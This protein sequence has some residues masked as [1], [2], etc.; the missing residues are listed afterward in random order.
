MSQVSGRTVVAAVL[1]SVPAPAPLELSRGPAVTATAD[2]VID[3]RVAR[4][5]PVAADGGLRA[6]G[7]GAVALIACAL[8]W[9]R[10]DLLVIATPLRRDHRLVGAH[11]T[12]VAH[13]RSTTGWATRRFAK[14]TRPSGTARSRVSPSWI[15]PSPRSATHRGSTPARRAASSPAARSTARPTS[16]S[17]CGR[18][19]G[20]RD[21]SGPCT[22][23]RRRPGPRS[24][25]R[26]SPRS[27]RLTTLPLP[28]V[29]DVHAT[30][31]PSD[32][33]IG[34]HRSA[35]SGEG[36]EFA[37]IRPFRAGDRLRRINW[38]RS[39]RSTELQVNSTWADLDTHIALVVDATDDFGVS[40]GIDGLA[41]SLDGAVRAAGA[42]AEHY[43]PRGERVS[44]RTFG[45]DVD[46]LGA[47][48]DRSRPTAS[49]PRHAGSAC[50][51]G[52]AAARAVSLAGSGRRRS[53]GGQITVMLSPLIAPEALDLVVSLGRQGMS[54]IVVDTL[55]DHVT[56][57]EDPVHRARVAHPP[58]RTAARAAGG[59][60]RRNSR[61]AVARTR[62]P[63][64]GHP[65]HR[66]SC[67]RAKDDAAMSVRL[68]QQMDRPTVAR[69]V[70]TMGVHRHRHVRRVR[71][72]RRPR[73]SPR[74]IR[75]LSSSRSS[76]A[77]AIASVISPDSHAALAVEVIVG[78]AVAREHRRRRPTLG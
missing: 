57:D 37:G 75:P 55:P 76:S 10:P 1:A 64:S 54:V 66:A 77:L 24:A 25:G 44:L 65:R 53:I 21:L 23:R 15:S 18:L 19:A 35:R 70:A 51:P 47:A 20:G 42:I 49:H 2:A 38:M 39:A 67:D 60:G 56:Q 28:P 8:I 14:A 48:G 71:V 6:C 7:G 43:A 5:E 45:H 30:A 9:R 61:R 32:G 11:P 22:S 12:E 46:P 4:P 29:F 50:E 31:R 26:P 13:R 36:N 34:L 69:V 68:V 16:T 59:A 73:R 3:A 17:V 27:T 58:A 74:G 41:S 72:R 33:L 62:E 78:V 40:E 63:R 52:P